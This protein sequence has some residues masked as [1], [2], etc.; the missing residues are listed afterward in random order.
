MKILKYKFECSSC[1][2]EDGSS[3]QRVDISGLAGGRVFLP[4][5]FRR[6]IPPLHLCF[7]L[8]RFTYF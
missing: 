2:R 5:K 7:S 6:I 1:F 3:M 4:P 8:H